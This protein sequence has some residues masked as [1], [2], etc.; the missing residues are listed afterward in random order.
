M[1]DSLTSDA[2]MRFETSEGTE[3]QNV[4]AMIVKR[5]S[6]SGK[7]NKEKKSAVVERVL[8]KRG[9]RFLSCS[10]PL[11]TRFVLLKGAMQAIC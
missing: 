6:Q 3:Y 4:N 2:V 10:M 9:C 11:K 7:E 5:K 1:N 8:K